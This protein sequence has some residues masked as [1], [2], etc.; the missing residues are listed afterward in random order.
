MFT[1]KRSMDIGG[2]KY[3]YNGFYKQK[4]TYQ[5]PI[6]K[7]RITKIQGARVSLVRIFSFFLF[8]SWLIALKRRFNRS[9]I[10]RIG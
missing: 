3:N 1:R 6:N 8:F 9:K 2:Y 5:M 7:G 4:S 10:M